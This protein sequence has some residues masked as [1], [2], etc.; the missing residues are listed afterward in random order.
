MRKDILTKKDEIQQWIAEERSKAF[1]C[2]ELHCKPDTLAVYLKKMGIIYKGKQGWNTTV[3]PAN[4]SYIPAAEYLGTDKFITSH[5][6]KIKLIKEGIK[7]NKCER[8]GCS[9]WLGQ[10]I[11]LE[12]HHKDGNHY[13]NK[14]NNL[15]ILC[16]NCHALTKNYRGKNID[17]KDSSYITDEKFKDALMTY[18][19]I[20]QALLALGL[21]A[22]GGN[23]VRARELAVK[24]NIKHILVP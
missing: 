19:N 8:C 20:R 24:Y 15:E 12:L 14:L 13:N 17:K 18:P 1:I 16:P 6:L 4:N 3:G 22:K 9:E 23:Y 5:N 10:P 2:R 11:P 7:E 21:T